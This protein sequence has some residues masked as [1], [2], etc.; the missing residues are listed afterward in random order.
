MCTQPRRVAAVTIAQRV[1]S[2]MGSTLGSTVG[3]TV[4]FDDRCTG[5]TRIKYVTD[6]VLLREIMGDRSLARLG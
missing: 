3:Y 6:G 4:R 2:E 5:T 1:A